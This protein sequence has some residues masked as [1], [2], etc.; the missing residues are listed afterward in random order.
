MRPYCGWT[1][2]LTLGV[3]T[4]SDECSS[5]SR[6][7]PHLSG[8][9]SLAWMGGERREPGNLTFD[10]P[11]VPLAGGEPQ[12]AC[13]SLIETAPESVGCVQMVGVTCPSFVMHNFFRTLASTFLVPPIPMSSP[14]PVAEKS[15]PPGCLCWQ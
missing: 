10:E 15:A 12:L 14:V 6:R 5:A 11:S 3:G 2:Y 1:P 7:W 9:V 4:D 13:L 8:G